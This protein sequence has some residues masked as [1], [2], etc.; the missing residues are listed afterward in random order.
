MHEAYTYT[1]Y[2]LRKLGRHREALRA[3]QSALD[4]QPDYPHAIEYQGQALLGLDRIDEAKFNYVRL[5]AL[6]Q[7]QAHKLLRAISAWADAHADRP[8]EGIDVQSLKLWVADRERT[9][10][11][12]DIRSSW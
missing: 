1:G 6:N 7:G 11:P 2:A 12:D 5:Y 4:I 3:Y 8:P 9:H 10:A